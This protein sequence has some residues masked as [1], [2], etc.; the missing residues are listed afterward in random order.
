M[1]ATRTPNYT[2]AL[3]TVLFT[4]NT[5]TA[6]GGESGVE[7]DA[8]NVYTT[9]WASNGLI[10]YVKAT[11]AYVSSFT[12]PG[13]TGLR[14]MANDGQYFYGG[15]AG[16]SIYKM[17]FA[18]NTLVSTISTSIAGIRHIAY[19]PNADGGNGGF[20]CGAWTTMNL[21]SKTGATLASNVVSGLVNVYGSALDNM[22]TGGPFL[23]TADQGNN[24]QTI[25]T[26]YKI[27]G[28]T[29]TA[30]GLTKDAG[31]LPGYPS[32]GSAGG[33]SSGQVGTKLA[34]IGVVQGAPSM[35]YAYELTDWSG[36][37]GGG[38]PAGLLGYKVYRDQAFLHYVPSPDTLHYYDM[39]L[40]PG[41]YCYDVTAYY[42][43]TP[44][45][46]AGQFDESLNAP[47]GPACVDISYGIDIPWTETFGNSGG[48]AYY[49]WTFG[50]SGQGNWS[51]N[52]TIGNPAPC[53]DFS[54]Q[55]IHANY[56]YSIVTPVLNAAGWTCADIFCDFDYKLID[57]AANSLEKMDVEMYVNGAWKPVTELVN[58]GSVEWT[59]Q[60][61]LLNGAKGHGFKLRFRANGASTDNIIHWYI[62]NVHVYGICKAPVLN[63]AS[64]SHFTTNLTWAAPVCGGGGQ[65]MDFIFDDGTGETG[66]GIN[67][68]YT[69]WLGNEFPIASSMN[70]VIQQFSVYFQSNASA[71]ADQ[72]TIEVFDGTQT[73][74]GM[75]DPFTPPTDAWL[76]IP[77][78][79]IPFNGMFYAMVKWGAVA[80]YTNYLSLDTD[81]PYAAQDLEWYYDGAA[82]NKIWI[83]AGQGV[84]GVYLLRAK[85]LVSGDLKQVVLNPAQPFVPTQMTAT[86]AKFSRTA[87]HVDTHNYGTMN[88]TSVP[89]SSTMIGYNVWRTDSTATGAFHKLNTAPVTT[90]AY[91]DTYPSTL[92]AG[93]FKYYV[94]ALFQNSQNPGAGVICEPPSDTIDVHFPAVGINDLSN[95][96]ISIYPNPANDIVNVAST[97][98]IKT[99]EVLN[100]IGQTVYTN[101]SVDGKLV[102]LHVSSYQAGVYFVRITTGSGIKTTKITIT[103]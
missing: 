52:N 85:A 2:D 27:N 16:T 41:H 19:D 82:W 43:L 55:P 23:W 49:N 40:D 86:P 1:V 89:D 48:F 13:V 88:V 61:F 4:W 99:L 96:S 87:K 11:G 57:R 71:G 18:T 21:V 53:A 17:D 62:D 20:W 56:D 67:P 37:G 28:T 77:V 51:V 66:W 97:I 8:T 12:I 79:D 33:L 74:V 36:G 64:Q 73:S 15:A 59:P 78:N 10:K 84:P 70:G 75:T 42:S 39:H 14:D 72:L 22:T 58:N 26:Q 65:V 3:W 91:T 32:G 60:H 68:T 38:T 54:W 69:A 5:Y 6:A 98:N 103:H 81:G 76:D 29:L 35:V 24:T 34:L 83:A 47:N 101:N 90:T 94:T 30:T 93:D 92:E 7:N 9:L 31:T 45:G 95:T 102:Q 25:L 63:A 50:T 46:L 100:Y 44:Y 80:G